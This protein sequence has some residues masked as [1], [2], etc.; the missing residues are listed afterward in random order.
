[1]V[2][3]GRAGK[4]RD[5]PA[6]RPLHVL[7]FAAACIALYFV[8]PLVERWYPPEVKVGLALLLGLNP[9]VVFVLTATYAAIAR[10]VWVFPL[11]AAALFVPSVYV[12]YND[13]AL[14]YAIFY[15]LAG[16]FGVAIGVAI[17]ALRPPGDRM[18]NPRV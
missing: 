3:T 13:S 9:L 16:G 11:L 2:D 5:R 12:H 4:G 15:L 14:I 10:P 18:T 6:F 8:V 1:M 7:T 17:R